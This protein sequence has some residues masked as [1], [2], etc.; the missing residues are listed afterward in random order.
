VSDPTSFLQEP[1][2][3]TIL[4]ERRH[5]RMFLVPSSALQRAVP[6]RLDAPHLDC[7]I[8]GRHDSHE[9]LNVTLELSARTTNRLF[10]VTNQR[11]GAPIRN[12]GAVAVF[13]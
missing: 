4:R 5:R 6:V 2:F 13:T 12:R 11:P 9:G 1:I 7:A 10:V 8:R 3:P